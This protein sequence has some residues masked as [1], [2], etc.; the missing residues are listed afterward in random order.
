MVIIHQCVRCN[1]TCIALNF[2][3]VTLAAGM[4]LGN[5]LGQQLF[6]LLIDCSSFKCIL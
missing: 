1:V 3:W 4:I 5:L 2:I 6:Q